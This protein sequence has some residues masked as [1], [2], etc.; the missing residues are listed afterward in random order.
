MV[1]INTASLRNSTRSRKWKLPTD[2]C[3]V[4]MR[5][6]WCSYSKVRRR[7]ARACYRFTKKRG[8][9]S[10]NSGHETTF[11]ILPTYRTH[12]GRQ[13]LLPSTRI[14]RLLAAKQPSNATLKCP[15]SLGRPNKPPLATSRIKI[16]MTCRPPV[17]GQMIST[18]EAVTVV[19][20]A[21][22]RAAVLSSD[23]RGASR[24]ESVR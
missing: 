19:L 6:S 10:R 1:L 8:R 2:G 7:A 16:P 4:A 22:D 14:R 24:M 12:H 20:A 15:T 17:S 5:E 21:R 13:A 23:R 3:G 11:R 18:T 9:H